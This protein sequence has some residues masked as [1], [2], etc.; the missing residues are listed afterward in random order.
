MAADPVMKSSPY[1]PPRA[2]SWSRFNGRMHRFEMRLRRWVACLG[3]PAYHLYISFSEGIPWLLIP[4]LMWRRRGRTKL[5]NGVLAAWAVLLV[6]HVTTL[7]VSLANLAA[8]AAS[9]LHAI[10]AAAVLGVIYPE[11]QGLSRVLKTVLFTSLLVIVIYSIGLRNL[12]APFAQRVTSQGVTVMTHGNGWFARRPW[13]QGEWVVYRFP[14]GIVGMDRILAGPGDT[15][16]FHKH[17][18]EVNGRHFERISKL[19]PS[20]GD[21]YLDKGIYFIW[22]T[23]AMFNHGGGE[24]LPEWL[25][26]LTKIPA[27]AIIGRPYRRWLGNSTDLANLKPVQNSI[28]DS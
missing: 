9:M 26:S 5:G 27:S 1:Y 14:N 25:L 12:V 23:T 20:D 6:V 19:M 10:S 11:W 18:F 21:V 22:P 17:S 16:R 24:D 28:P 15:I 3:S 13:M 7:N 4:G 2:G 8:T